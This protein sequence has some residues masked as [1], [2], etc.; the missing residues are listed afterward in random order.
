MP[1]QS[2]LPVTTH[3]R[4]PQVRRLMAEVITYG[5]KGLRLLQERLQRQG[6][7]QGQGQGE[8]QPQEGVQGR[9][10]D[11]QGQPGGADGNDEDGG[12]DGWPQRFAAAL[13]A[14]FDLRCGT[15][16]W[17]WRPRPPSGASHPAQPPP[18]SVSCLAASY[19]WA[20]SPPAAAT[21]KALL[22]VSRLAPCALQHP[23]P[24]PSYPPGAPCS[25]TR[26][27]GH[28]T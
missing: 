26:C 27:W 28:A 16:P 2:L 12:P 3:P 18:R 8:Q 5:D 10:Q 11:Q 15:C 21:L 9:A 4:H 13:N 23:L 17:P 24:A 7:G 1:P 20:P 19:L 6:Q 22:A 14:N 25:V